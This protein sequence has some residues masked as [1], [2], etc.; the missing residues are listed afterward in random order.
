VTVAMDER[1]RLLI[2]QSVEQAL[3]SFESAERALD[4]NRLMSHFAAVP[5]FHIFNDGQRL[6]YDEMTEVLRATFPTLRSIEGGFSDVSVMV[7]A[8]DAAL[9]TARFQETVTDGTGNIM[10]QHGAA[11]WLW[12]QLDR[13]WRIVYGH[14]DHYPDAV[15]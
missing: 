11:S 13:E 1:Q 5:E 14:I 4:V 10:R 8:S 12:R 9:S 15:Q 7:L 3:R 2:A 6:S